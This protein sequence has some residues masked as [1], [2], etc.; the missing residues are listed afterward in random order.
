MQVPETKSASR[1]GDFIARV[2]TYTVLH[3]LCR[4]AF[5]NALYGLFW[6]CSA[7]PRQERRNVEY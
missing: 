6:F 3:V 4:T 2:G 1:E 5:V 7:S